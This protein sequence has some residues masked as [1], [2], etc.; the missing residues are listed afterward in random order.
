MHGGQD[1]RVFANLAFGAQQRVLEVTVAAPVTEP[2]ALTRHRHRAAHD[3]IDWTH[4]LRRQ[5]AAE[6]HGAA[7]AADA[8]DLGAEFLRIEF[9]EAAFAAQ[10]GQ[11]DVDDLALKQ[12]RTPDWQLWRIAVDLDGLGPL[13]HRQLAEQLCRP[14]GADEVRDAGVH[15]R[16][17]RHTGEH[18][19]RAHFLANLVLGHGADRG[20]KIGTTRLRWSQRVWGLRPRSRGAPRR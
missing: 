13:P 17:T 1:R 9:D 5:K 6:L 20:G 8:Q 10:P 18:E 11:A 4:L 2:G 7:H 3:E 14:L 16:K 15:T 19:P 12:R